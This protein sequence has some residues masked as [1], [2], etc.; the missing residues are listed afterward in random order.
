MVDDMMMSEPNKDC[1]I[2]PYL[3][4]RRVR[5][6]SQ[7]SSQLQL[8]S[9]LHFPLHAD[10]MGDLDISLEDRQQYAWIMARTLAIMHWIGNIDGNDIEFVLAPPNKR[11]RRT[12]EIISNTL[13]EHSVWVL[14]FD[15]C[16]ALM[17]DQSKTLL[18][19][20]GHSCDPLK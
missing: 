1:L 17:L 12:V 7:T 6:E 14:D 5:R 9:L 20:Q 8:F 18:K 3:S 2:R 16:R 4:R 19:C 10:Q 11:N 13:G 15:C